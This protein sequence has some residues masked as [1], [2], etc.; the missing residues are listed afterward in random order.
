MMG[1]ISARSE[2]SYSR[3]NRRAT[4]LPCHIN[5]R[6][7]I[8]EIIN[9]LTEATIA[10][11]YDANGDPIFLVNPSRKEVLE[12]LGASYGVGRMA[13]DDDGNV[14]IW[15][16][17]LMTHSDVANR[18]GLKKTGSDN[19]LTGLSLYAFKKDMAARVH[20][21]GDEEVHPELTEYARN[22][23]NIVKIWGKDV[24]CIDIHGEP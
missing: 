8:R 24:V 22:L 2:G 4:P 7:N 5:I 1:S 15:Q 18:Y 13:V 19:P 3:H 12:L 11:A 9:V 16:A 21:V 23:P 14:Y 17:S 20:E 6:M 10:D